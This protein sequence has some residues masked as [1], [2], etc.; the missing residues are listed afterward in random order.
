LYDEF[1]FARVDV[2]GLDEAWRL[3]VDQLTFVV[4]MTEADLVAKLAERSAT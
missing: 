3:D 2:G 4:R 1:G